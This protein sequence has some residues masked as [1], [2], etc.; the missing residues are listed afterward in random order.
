[1]NFYQPGLNSWFIDPAAGQQ[2]AQNGV[3]FNDMLEAIYATAGSP[4]ADVETAF[5]VTDFSHTAVLQGFGPVPQSVY[6]VCTLTW[7]CNQQSGFDI[8]ANSDG[9]ARIAQAFATVLGV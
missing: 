9:Y 4:V 1:M 7:A 2:A 5:S 6:A 3:V 8:H